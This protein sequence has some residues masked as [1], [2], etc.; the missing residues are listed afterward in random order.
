MSD[1]FD[2]DTQNPFQPAQPTQQKPSGDNRDFSRASGKDDGAEEL[3]DDP[4]D[5]NDGNDEEDEFADLWDRTDSEDEFEGVKS[6]DLKKSLSNFK[7]QIDQDKVKQMLADGDP[8]MFA[9]LM[10][11]VVSQ[12]LNVSVLASNKLATTYAGQ[13]KASTKAAAATE[14]KLGKITDRL[15]EVYPKLAKSRSGSGVMNSIVSS[16]LRKDKTI[17]V[18]AAFKKAKTYLSEQLS[19]EEVKQT[20]PKD[21]SPSGR[22][23]GI[24]TSGWTK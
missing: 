5:K 1:F 2:K 11:D 22:Q 15:A 24:Q 7:P 23:S 8:A 14:A 9:E 21:E 12:A 20:K 10:G 19:I 16:I 4:I 13:T 18:D 3:K 17:S 6:E